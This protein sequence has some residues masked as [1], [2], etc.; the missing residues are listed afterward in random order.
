MF[1]CMLPLFT[2]LWDLQKKITIVKHFK[3]LLDIY[4]LLF[5]INYNP[6]GNRFF[7]NYPFLP[8]AA[9]CLY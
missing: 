3:Y 2:N 4:Y 7:T 1:S 6:L 9:M 5:Q 8:V